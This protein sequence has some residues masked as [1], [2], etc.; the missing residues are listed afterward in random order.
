MSNSSAIPI[1]DVQSQK[2]VEGTF[3]SVPD[4][5]SRQKNKQC[6][7]HYENIF[8][9]KGFHI[10]PAGLT[11]YS[12]GNGETVYSGIRVSG[13]YENKKTKQSHSFL[14]T[15]P[16]Q[17][18][19][20]SI[21]KSSNLKSPVNYEAGEFDKELV[22]FCLH[23]VRKY[24]LTIKRSSEEFLTSKNKN[25]IDTEK[26]MKTIFASSTSITNRLNIYDFESNPEIVTASTPFN[27]SVFQKFQKASR[28]LEIYARDAG[29]KILTFKGTL[30]SQ[31]DM[32]PIFDFVPHVLLENAI[33]Y[34]PKDQ[35]IDV[36]FEEYNGS[37]EVTV[38]SIGPVVSK[39]E[40]GHVFEKKNRAHYAKVVDS[41][42]GG[43]GLYF[44]KLICELHDIAINVESG[45]S[46]LTLDSIPYSKFKVQLSYKK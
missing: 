32:Y 34:S 35:E 33:K 42:G 17:I 18:V 22:D 7:K 4:L 43:Y 27:A 46:L 37:F 19:M 21:Y 24:N 30:R 29:V 28:C 2:L 3:F 31:I 8:S 10:C 14:P 44:A 13:Y 16:P 41:S 23:E 12:L 11:S 40:L 20:E 15:I 38:E 45:P 36:I 25:V 6:R 5:C 26:L 39:E 9:K 1:W